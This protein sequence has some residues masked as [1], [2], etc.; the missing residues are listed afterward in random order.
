MKLFARY[1][2]EIE[3]EFN[4]HPFLRQI[5]LKKEREISKLERE[6]DRKILKIDAEIAEKKALAGK[7]V[8]EIQNPDDDDKNPDFL[9]FFLVFGAAILDFLMNFFLFY[10][11]GFGVGESLFLG[12]VLSGGL[13]VF[14]H[15]YKEHGT[16]LNRVFFRIILITLTIL[17]FESFLNTV[18]SASHLGKLAFF[19]LSLIISYFTIKLTLYVVKFFK[20]LGIKRLVKKIISLLSLK[21]HLEKEKA[22][23]VYEIEKYFDEIKEEYLLW[24][25]YQQTC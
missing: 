18:D 21:A 5:E 8:Q 10:W 12:L 17:R 25:R 3:A 24:K 11:W 4:D 16:M 1:R 13:F 7:V 2:A 15:S 6:I 22:K 9:H 14:F 20:L 19:M 23:K